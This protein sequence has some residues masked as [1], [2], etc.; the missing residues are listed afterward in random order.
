MLKEIAFYGTAFIV[1]GA[2]A[3]G[4]TGYYGQ[5]NNKDTSKVSTRSHNSGQMGVTQSWAKVRR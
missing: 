2:L 4:S 5:F 3:Y 1:L